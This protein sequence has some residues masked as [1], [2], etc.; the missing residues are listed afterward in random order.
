MPKRKPRKI[1]EV[2][3]GYRL[4][5][6]SEDKLKEM[7]LQLIQKHLQDALSIYGYEVIAVPIK[8]GLY[9]TIFTKTVQSA[10][11]LSSSELRDSADSHRLCRV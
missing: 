2:E 9:G 8:L 7:C 3:A 1:W 11:T 10:Q 6:M 5:T 4:D